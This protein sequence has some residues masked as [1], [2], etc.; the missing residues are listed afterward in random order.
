MRVRGLGGLQRPRQPRLACR[1]ASL[2]DELVAGVH[3]AEPP[4]RFFDAAV[5]AG[6]TVLHAPRE[7]PEYH[8][9]QVG[10]FVRG[11]D[12]NNVETVCHAG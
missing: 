11:A 1:H 12:G 10:A 9:G 4:R 5:V 8:P 2:G 6:A 3:G 7:W